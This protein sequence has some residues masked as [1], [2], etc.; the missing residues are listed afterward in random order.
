[1]ILGM[2]KLLRLVQEKNLIK[3][4]SEREL[5]KP[6]GTGFD[7]RIGELY[8]LEEE[9]FLGVEERNTPKIKLIAKYDKNNSGVVELMPGRY[10][11]M[12]TIE[13]VNCPEDLAGMILSRSTLFRSGV[14]LL[15][16]LCDPGYNGQLTFGLLNNHNRPFKLEMGARVAN[17]SFHRVDGKANPYNGQWQGGRIGTEKKEKH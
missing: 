17:I 13:T 3:D 7:L 12:R 15:T 4:L 10:Y 14:I 8:E 9:G 11:V 5:T 1:M 16:S 2:D 6:T